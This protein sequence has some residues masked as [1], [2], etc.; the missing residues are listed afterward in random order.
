MGK[1]KKHKDKDKNREHKKKR[2]HKSRSKSRD[3]SEKKHKHHREGKKRKKDK[4]RDRDVG[5]EGFEGD[6]Y[7]YETPYATGQSAPIPGLGDIHLPTTMPPQHQ[8]QDSYE[9]S[10]HARDSAQIPGLDGM[11]PENIYEHYGE[12]YED[13]EIPAPAPEIKE[14]VEMEQAPPSGYEGR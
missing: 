6:R 4:D 8:V 3:R 11:P 1:E 5:N 9:E 13:G 12:Y 7:D 2:K 10:Y 14:E